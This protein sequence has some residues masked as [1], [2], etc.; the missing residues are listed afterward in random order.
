MPW[1]SIF[2]FLFYCWVS[3]QHSQSPF[4]PSSRGS[5]V[6]LH[7]LPVEWYQHSLWSNS[8]ICTGL[9]EKF[10]LWLYGPLLA[11]WCLCFFN[12]LSRF[13]IAFLPRG[14]CIL[15]SQMQ[16]PSSD[17]GAQEDKICHCFHFLHIYLQWT[18][19]LRCHDLHFFFLML[20]FKPA[21]SLSSFTL[22]KRLLSSSSLSA[23]TVIS[24]VY[25]SLLVFLPEILL[26][27]CDSSSLVFC[28]MYSAYKLNKQVT[29]YRFDI[30]HFLF[31]TG[32]LFHVQF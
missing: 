8:H 10:Q 18:V 4:S 20:T 29:I 31:R 30:L 24:S 26:P 23:I 9:L 1:S 6:P 11:K 14:K 12:M 25:L 17:F 7:F 22:L 3:S 5:S 15:I 21:I 27:A 19:G 16:S 13:V 32:L 28:M 2:F